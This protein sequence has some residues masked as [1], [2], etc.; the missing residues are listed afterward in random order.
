MVNEPRRTLLGVTPHPHAHEQLR[1]R[2]CGFVR[3]WFRG[4]SFTGHQ[5]SGVTEDTAGNAMLHDW[6]LEAK[7]D[8]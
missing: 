5:C 4:W 2:Q 7:T 3:E 8:A 1:C 6:V